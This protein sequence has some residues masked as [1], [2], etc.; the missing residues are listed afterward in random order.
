MNAALRQAVIEAHGRLERHTAGYLARRGIQASCAKGCFACCSAWVVVGLAEA[1]YL[2]E[3]L[4][5]YQPEA[6][7][8]LE[9]EGAN[10]W[11]G[12]LDKSTGPISP[13]G[14]SWKTAPARCL[15]RRGPARRTHTAL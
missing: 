10:G 14:I 8:R 12:L 9:A 1:E 4:E 2:R 15:R 3:A 13:P 5:A 11:R 6:L 7:A